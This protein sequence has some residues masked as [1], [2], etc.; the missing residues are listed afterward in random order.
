MSECPQTIEVETLG[1]EV[2]LEVPTVCGPETV[3]VDSYGIETVVE[4]DS[5]G[6]IPGPPGPPGEGFPTVT[7]IADLDTLD[8]SVVLLDD[9]A[10]VAAVLGADPSLL[11]DGPVLVSSLG[12]LGGMQIFQT[13]YLALGEYQRLIVGGTTAGWLPVRVPSPSQDGVT[14]LSQPGPVG[15]EWNTER[16]SSTATNQAIVRRDGGGRAQVN[17]PIDPLD[18]ANKAYVDALTGTTGWRDCTTTDI[19]TGGGSTVVPATG[20]YLLARDGNLVHMQLES[21]APTSATSAWPRIPSG[22]WPRPG[23]NITVA[24]WD[25]TTGEPILMRSGG[26]QW[27]NVLGGRPLT[28]G[29]PRSA[30]LSWRTSQ[31]FPSTLPGVPA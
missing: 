24:I 26:N 23:S 30:T 9:I 27:T 29:S 11:D 12:L 18:I 13:M 14:L 28:A 31:N 10:G 19:V 22:F 1:S 16:V 4:V 20:R 5:R 7:D 3:E 2:T 21:L 8:T 25:D 17:I 15:Y 6:M